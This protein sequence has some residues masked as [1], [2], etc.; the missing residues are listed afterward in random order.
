VQSQGPQDLIAPNGYNFTFDLSDLFDSS[1]YLTFAIGEINPQLVG[2]YTVNIDGFS[3]IPGPNPVPVLL[4]TWDSLVAAKTSQNISTTIAS[5]S[6]PVVNDL[7]FTSEPP[8]INIKEIEP[9]NYEIQVFNAT[10][11]LCTIII[12]LLK[13]MGSNWN[14][15]RQ[16]IF[17]TAGSSTKPVTSLLASAI[18]YR[19]HNKLSSTYQ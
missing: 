19:I 10:A 15:S 3:F 16:M 12:G 9:T 2:N 5:I 1:G 6:T 13:L 17:I 11:P 7:N 4:N 18:C 14:T 8:L